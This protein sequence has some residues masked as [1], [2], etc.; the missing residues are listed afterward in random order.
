MRRKVATALW[1]GWITS[2]LIVN[3]LIVPVAVE[4]T[5]QM[6]GVYLLTVAVIFYAWLVSV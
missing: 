2:V 1:I 5:R 3:V 6:S 4:D